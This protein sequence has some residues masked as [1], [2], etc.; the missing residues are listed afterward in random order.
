MS[1]LDLLL[2]AVLLWSVASS[3]SKGFVREA[4]GLAAS[5][6]G[7]LCGAWFYRM[8]AAP[9]EPYIG[10]EPIANLC[11]FLLIFVGV[12]LAGRLV[13]LL[14]GL[15]V[16]AVGLSFLNR[17]LGAAFGAARGIVV[18]VALITA[19]VAFSPGRDSKDPPQAVVGSRIAPYMLDAA[20]ALM[21][22]AP[23]EMRDQFAQGYEKVR[24]LWEEA[25]RHGPR[26]LPESEI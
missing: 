26:R 23:R 18:C 7:L 19:I 20:H 14:V 6:A 3:F 24:R 17:L 9:I 12:L 22:V 4:I 25:M 10:S 8:A 2:G 15:M 1:W 13:S 21:M 16:K 11:G 5:I